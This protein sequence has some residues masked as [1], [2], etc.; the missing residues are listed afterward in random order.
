MEDI[1]LNEVTLNPPSS[2]EVKSIFPTQVA[3]HGSCLTVIASRVSF[4]PA[5]PVIRLNPITKAV[6]KQL[7]PVHDQRMYHNTPVLSCARQKP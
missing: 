4:W 3:P 7:L 1:I 6:N 5:E 2:K